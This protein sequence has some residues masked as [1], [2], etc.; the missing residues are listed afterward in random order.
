M[1]ENNRKLV[2][3]RRNTGFGDCIMSMISA[4]HYA[5]CTGRTLIIDWRRSP[6]V[7]EKHKNAFSAFFKPVAAIGDVPVICDDAIKTLGIPTPVYL[8]H[9]IYQTGR[10]A[11]FIKRLKIVVKPGL[12]ID[13]FLRK[14]IDE[15]YLFKP[16][17]DVPESTVIFRSC[18]PALAEL[19]DCQLVL[20]HLTP[21]EGIQ[22]EIEQYVQANFSGK[23]VIAVHV[24]H[25]NG[26]DIMGHAEYWEDEARVIHEICQEIKRTKEKVGQDSLVFLCT[27]SKKIQETMRALFP[28]IIAR[29]K[30]F[31]PNNSGELHD[32]S[33]IALPGAE[34]MG[35][36]ALTEMFLLSRAHALIT[37]PPGSY[38]SFYARQCENGPKLR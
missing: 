1:S 18:L 33:T 19:Q 34:E 20:R 3:S 5:K 21:R 12:F 35:S 30:Y 36:D 13:A 28:G 17:H 14:M 37:Y 2:V 38:F 10:L 31:R 9:G 11:A 27:D 6:Y 16:I 23:K 7:K 26:G 15:L 24:R 22:K 4:W 32:R 25:G 29:Q 8:G